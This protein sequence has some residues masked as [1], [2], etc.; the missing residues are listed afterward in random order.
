MLRESKEI[1]DKDVD[2]DNLESYFSLDERPRLQVG[3]AEKEEKEKKALIKLLDN[4]RSDAIGKL[5]DKEGRE[6]KDG[7]KLSKRRR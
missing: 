7:G 2:V 4:K 6:V 3:V 5:I 1:E